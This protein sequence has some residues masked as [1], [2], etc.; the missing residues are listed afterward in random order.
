MIGQLLGWLRAL[1]AVA[2]IGWLLEM[3][4]PSLG[5][6]RYVRLVVGLFVTWAILSPMVGYFS[7]KPPNLPT[8]ATTGATVQVSGA[9]T[10]TALIWQTYSGALSA[11]AAALAESQMGVATAKA[12]VSFIHSRDPTTAGRPLAAIVQITR[13][14]DAPHNLATLVQETVASGL[15]LA[16]QKVSV[17]VRG[18]SAGPLGGDHIP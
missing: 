18:D 15:G 17:M 2:I 3:M 13:G 6:R 5:M 12:V 9:Q 10:N 4:I 7:G 8:L 16:A 1:C 14:A 11:D